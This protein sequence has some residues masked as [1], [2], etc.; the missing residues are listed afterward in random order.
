MTYLVAAKE[1]S[2]IS[3]RFMHHPV[4]DSRTEPRWLKLAQAQVY[5]TPVMASF[6]SSAIPDLMSTSLYKMMHRTPNSTN[7]RITMVDKKNSLE[8]L[9]R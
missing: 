3:G 7:H 5:G 6:D 1:E 4:T 8:S 2:G 9:G